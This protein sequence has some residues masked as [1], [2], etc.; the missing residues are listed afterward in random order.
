MFLTALEEVRIGGQ[1]EAKLDDSKVLP[2]AGWYFDPQ[3]LPK[4]ANFYVDVVRFSE[5]RAEWDF[6]VH[7]LF[8]TQQALKLYKGSYRFT[9]LVTGDNAEPAICKLDV[10]YD[11]TWSSIRANPSERT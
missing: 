9:L 2:W 3:D 4:G 5:K 11:G 6:C 10:H 1:V 8:Q 7:Q